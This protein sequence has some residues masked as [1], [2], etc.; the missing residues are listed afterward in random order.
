MNSLAALQHGFLQHLREPGDA[1]VHGVADGRLAASTGLRI[2]AH[3]YRARLIEALD[4]DHPVLGT[5][6]GDTLWAQLCDGYIATHPSR[7][8]SLR[9]FG[10]QLPAYLA[11]TVPFADDARI[12][13]I[14]AFERVL[15]DSFDAADAEPLPFDALLARAPTDWPALTPTLHPGVRVLEV[16]TNAVDAWSAIKDDEAP[17]PSAA[18]PVPAW[19]TW[20]DAERVGRFRSLTVREHDALARV[21]D[22]GDIA[23]L[24]ESL[25]ERLTPAEVPGAA[26]QLL[27][28]WFADGWIVAL[29]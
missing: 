1:T 23:A 19:A 6:L 9:D 28:A 13:E 25:A 14:A 11:A 5:Y 7:V 4:N 26:V 15:L 18:S 12:A 21:R 29:D 24:C 3:A 20:R 16:R 22:G 10:A 27:Q 17:P 2:Y 8:R